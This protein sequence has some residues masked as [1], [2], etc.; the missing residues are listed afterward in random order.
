MLRIKQFLFI[1]MLFVSLGSVSEAAPGLVGE[2]FQKASEIDDKGKIVGHAKPFYVRVDKHVNFKEVSGDFY[3]TKLSSN[4]AV[5]WSGSIKIEQAGE[6]QFA[7]SSDDGSMVY[8]NG[9]QVVGNW[10][11]HSWTKKSGGIELQKGSHEIMVLL[12]QFGGGAGCVLEWTPPGGKQ[13]IVLANVLSHDDA[14]AKVEWDQVAW[15]KIKVNKSTQKKKGGGAPYD[16]KLY[17]PALGLP[18]RFHESSDDVFRGILVRLD[19][20]GEACM[21]FD[22][23][24]MRMAAGWTEGGLVLNGLPFTGG[25]GAVPSF[26]GESL[27]KSANAPGWS[28]NDSFS[29]P[30][31]GG[32][33]PPLG[34]LPKAHAKFKGWYLHGKK[35]VFSYTVG[36]AKVLEHP[37]LQGA[38]KKVLVRHFQIEGDGQSR[39]FIVS[40]A[41]NVEISGLK[42]KF[43]TTQVSLNQAPDGTKLEQ[44]D[45]NLV[46]SL[47]GFRGTERFSL[48]FSDANE[49]GNVSVAPIDL[50][51]LTKGGPARWETD[52]PIVTQGEISEDD[53]QAYVIDRLTLPQSP[54]GGQ[55]RVGGFDF[56]KDGKSAAFSTWSGEVWIV[57]GIDDSL[58]NLTWKK[59]ASGLHEPLGLKIVD[60]KIYTVADDQITRYHDLNHDGEADYYETFNND[61]DLTSGFHAFCFDLH[62]DP[63]ENFYFGFGCP[64][65]GG[66]RSFERLGRHHGSIIR[67]SKDGSK[68]ERYASGLRAPNGIGVSPTGQVTSG[69]NEGTFVPRCP[70]HWIE[71]GEFLGVVDSYEHYDKLKTTPTVSQRR[72]DRP[73]HLER[74]EMPLPLA[75]LP[76]KVDNSNGGQAWVTSEKW[77]PFQG[78][79]L[80]MSYGQS[81]L[82]LVLKEKKGDL[83]QGGVV[84]FPVRFTSSAMRAR[85]S[86]RDGQL[87]VTGLRGWQTNAA[88]NGGIDRVRYTGKKVYMPVG[89]KVKKNGLEITFSQPLDKELAADPDSYAVQGADI[90]WAQQYGT[91]EYKIGFRDKKTAPGGWTEMYVED[92]KLLPDGKTV[93]IEVE[94]MQPVHEME[95]DID[96]EAA[97][98]TAIRTKINNTVHVTE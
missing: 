69:D 26:V 22:A 94:N 55:M 70:I 47:P 84:K 97:D 98:G 63:A 5:R 9:K 73:E 42:A 51:P 54:F 19:E 17:G 82:Y 87:Y 77:G 89:L 44:D 43:D 20:S 71:Q 67:V 31:T 21:L 64:V 39:K 32:G 45:H 8:I 49:E 65:R 13:S 12:T 3:G 61:W 53:K 83:M 72:G 16:E 66:G 14:L 30:R 34:P 46:V 23:D 96:V 56:F 86:P 74:S 76:K 15:K 75:W 37:A 36:G 88:K 59:F 50:T 38:E 6:Y 95:I 91:S 40:R 4:F 80:H 48:V 52:E 57:S 78:E 60:E 81:S 85:F 10:G 58:E 18:L 27:F 1:T 35:V 28:H 62:N 93:F 79:M 68:L 90:K 2:Y 92:A 41:P 33:T 29:E 24:T 25:H 7:T 11:P